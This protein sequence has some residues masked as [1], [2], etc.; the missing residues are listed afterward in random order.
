MKI[1]PQL[2]PYARINAQRRRF[3]CVVMVT[4]SHVVL[5]VEVVR[6]TKFFTEEFFW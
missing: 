5:T 4:V 1:V 3:W 6:L 2:I